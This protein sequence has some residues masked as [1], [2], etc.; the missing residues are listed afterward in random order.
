[1]DLE[2]YLIWKTGPQ[3]QETQMGRKLNKNLMLTELEQLN[4]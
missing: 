3:V 1:M 2:H 4:Y